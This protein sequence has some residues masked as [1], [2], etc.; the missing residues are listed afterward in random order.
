MSDKQQKKPG[1][2]KRTIR[3]FLVIFVILLIPVSMD[4]S[5]VDPET[6]RLV[7]RV[8]GGLTLLL[9]LYGLFTKVL[10]FAGFLLLIVLA[11]V[12]LMSERQLEFPRLSEM[13]GSE[14]KK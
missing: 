12:V 4:Q 6:V 11:L 7:G 1:A 14:Q 10:K 3:L 5:G 2:I 8:A 9:I 13:L